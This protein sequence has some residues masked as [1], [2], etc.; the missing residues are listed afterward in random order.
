MGFAPLPADTRT[1]CLYAAF[2]AHSLQFSSINNY[3]GIIALLHKEFYLPKPSSDNWALKS[4]LSGI[5][6][7]KGNTIKQ[8]LSITLH[9]LSGIHRVINLCTSYDST[10]WDVCLIAFL[11]YSGNL[12]CCLYLR[13]SMIPP[14]SFLDLVSVNFLIGEHLF[15]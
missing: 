8:K 2:L 5:K 7:V 9:I 14:N 10:F 11:D 13:N 1:I 12:I 4:R 15:M 3:L 6:R